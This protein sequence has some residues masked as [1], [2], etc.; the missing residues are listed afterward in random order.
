MIGV[1]PA[2]VPDTSLAAQLRE[3]L[4]RRDSIQRAS[5]TVYQ[6]SGSS[7]TVMMGGLLTSGLASIQ[8]TMRAHFAGELK[9]YNA[10]IGMTKVDG[11]R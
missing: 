10:I 2:S 5:M 11:W 6:S 3:M 4:A 8:A 1:A 9:S 7:T